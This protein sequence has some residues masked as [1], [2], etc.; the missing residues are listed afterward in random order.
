MALYGKTL[1]GRHQVVEGRAPNQLLKRLA[2]NEEV[3]LE[4][5]ELLTDAVKENHR[6]IPA[7][8]WLL[9]NFYLIQ[10]QIRTGKKHL[11]KGYSEDLPQLVNGPSAGLPRVYD[12]ALEIISH[13]DGRVDLQGLSHFITSYQSVTHLKLGELWAIPIMLRLALIENL[14]R[15]SAQISVDRIN[16]NLAGYWAEQMTQTAEKDPKSLILVIA[17]M[18]RSGP[19]MVSSFVA[20]LA[21]LLQGRGPALALPLTWIE[22]RLSETGQT[23]NELVQAEFQKQ[24]ADQVSM[25]NSISSLRFLGTTDWRE[26]VETTSIVEQ[27]LLQ[28]SG[29]TYAY[30][31]FT[32]R[33]DYRHTVEKIARYSPTSEEEVARLAIGLAQ[34]AAS[35]SG[36]GDRTAHVGYFLVGKGRRQL[37]KAA[38]MRLPYADRLEKAVRRHPLL[39]YLSAIAGISLLIGGS[40][41][42]RTQVQGIHGALL[43]VVSLLSLLCASQLAITL[44]NWM[45]TLFIK[46]RLLPRMDFSKGVPPECRTLVVVPTLFTNEAELDELIEDLEVRFLAN[47]DERLHF[48]LLTDFAD[49]SR[50]TLPEDAPL[51]LKAQQKME[52]LNTKY[53]SEHNSIFFLFHRPRRWNTRDHIW[54]GYERKRGKLTELN[55]LLRGQG[56]DYFS[57]VVGEPDLFPAIKYVITLDT[58]TKL[59][60]RCGLEKIV[61]A[62]MAHP[63]N[64]AVYD[65]K[66]NKGSPRA[67]ASCSPGWTPAW[68]PRTVPAMHACTAMTWASTPIPW[69]VRMCTRICSTKVHLS[70]KGSMK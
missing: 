59:P 24:A 55:S 68:H 40:F 70:G 22:Q 33:D 58:D 35:H 42:V 69:P 37:E 5:H 30:M 16:Q 64:K 8:E 47:R 29:R 20:E 48:G 15:L 61:S 27:V 45:L 66:R 34:S 17:D 2:G 21:R 44:V 31:D 51:L 49:A 18:A 43:I 39:V 25:S 23:S 41:F 6:I 4:V 12:I 53:G 14:R 60:K 46:P 63:L 3:L 19:P 7:G 52:A 26:F 65:E 9:D 11:P 50:E 28:D 32:T 38:R 56:A 57:L 62:A 10:D 13:S 54:M 1:A 67:M 36:A